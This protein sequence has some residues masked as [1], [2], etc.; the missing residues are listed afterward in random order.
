MPLRHVS[1]HRL[2]TQNRIERRRSEFH[3]L[4]TEGLENM[5]SETA[6]CLPVSAD[7]TANF[8]T[9]LLQRQEPA[10]FSSFLEENRGD[11]AVRPSSYQ[12]RYPLP[13]GRNENVFL[14]THERTNVSILVLLTCTQLWYTCCRE[15]SRKAAWTHSPDPKSVELIL[16]RLLLVHKLIMK[17]GHVVHTILIRLLMPMSPRCMELSKEHTSKSTSV[18]VTPSLL[19]PHPQPPELKPTNRCLYAIDTHIKCYYI[20]PCGIVRWITPV[21]RGRLGSL[22]STSPPL[23]RMWREAICFRFFG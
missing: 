8:R 22:L 9:T 16:E 5:Y 15:K 6:H 20:A 11:Q 23:R 1:Q 4:D 12:A 14:G 2:H 21:D 19:T 17:V 10:S 13:R 18:F 7:G 3:W